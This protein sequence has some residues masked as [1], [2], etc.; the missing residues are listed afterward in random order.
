MIETI[1]SRNAACRL[2]FTT[3]LAGCRDFMQFSIWMT[4]R[5]VPPFRHHHQR[6]SCPERDRRDRDATRE[7]AAET[8]NSSR[9]RR[10]HEGQEIA[11]RT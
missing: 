8:G 6:D 4:R 5:I 9:E 2:L 1:V 3:T 11:V 7:T 10:P